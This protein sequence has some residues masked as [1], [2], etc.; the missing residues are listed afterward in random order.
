MLIC[1]WKSAF[2]PF[3]IPKV[4]LKSLVPPFILK[5]PLLVSSIPIL[6]SGPPPHFFNLQNLSPLFWNKKERNA[7]SEVAYR[8]ELSL[9]GNSII[10][11]IYFESQCW[12]DIIVYKYVGKKKTLYKKLLS[13]NNI[14]MS[15]QGFK[16]LRQ[17]QIL[18]HLRPWTGVQAIFCHIECLKIVIL[19]KSILFYSACARSTFV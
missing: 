14:F 6:F 16:K 10:I 8:K 3:F 2:L 5:T 11:G 15:N 4:N 19:I 18:R 12:W 13:P 9:D 1:L 7:Q 17:F